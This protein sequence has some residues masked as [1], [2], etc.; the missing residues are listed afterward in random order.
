MPSWAWFDNLRT[1]L[2]VF[3]NHE[4]KILILGWLPPST[5]SARKRHNFRQSSDFESSEHRAVDETDKHRFSWACRL[6]ET[7]KHQDFPGNNLSERPDLFWAANFLQHKLWYTSFMFGSPMVSVCVL[8]HPS[9]QMCRFTCF[10]RW[11][12]VCIS[13]FL[14]ACFCVF[15]LA[16]VLI[17]VF[18]LASFRFS[19]DFGQVSIRKYSEIVGNLKNENEYTGMHHFA[20]LLLKP[21]SHDSN[22]G[23]VLIIALV[24]AWSLFQDR[25]ESPEHSCYTALHH[26]STQ[27]HKFHPLSNSATQL[28]Q[29]KLWQFIIIH[30]NCPDWQWRSVCNTQYSILRKTTI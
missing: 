5:I 15:D 14:L 26:F 3:E 9:W 1:S 27:A 21:S 8:T 22:V 17:R 20:I 16:N 30:P 4:G 19:P 10:R 24:V 29:I 12:K 2:I 6:L 18:K 23:G 13:V 7:Y 28:I 25:S 11:G